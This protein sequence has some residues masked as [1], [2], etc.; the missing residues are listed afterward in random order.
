MADRPPIR[1]ANRY[2]A[3]GL[4]STVSRRLAE[5]LLRLTTRRQRAVTPD[6]VVAAVESDPEH[7][8]RSALVDPVDDRPGAV[9]LAQL[10]NRMRLEQGIPVPPGRG[11]R[12]F[13]VA[14]KMSSR[15]RKP[16]TG[17]P[18]SRRIARPGPTADR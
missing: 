12:S 2:G 11:S 18:S 15:E 17:R 6:E 4:F 1:G 13:R 7:V 16:R 9:R 8:P 5:E 3:L 10:V 14:W